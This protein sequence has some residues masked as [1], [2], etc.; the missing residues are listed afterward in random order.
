M[1]KGKVWLGI[2]CTALGLFGLWTALVRWVDVQ[3]IGPEGSKI[4]F[5]TM[6]GW[7][8]AVT[9]VDW[10]LYNITDWLGLVPIAVCFGFA[11]LGL[12]QWIRR[13]KI[14][15]V[16]YDIRCLGVYYLTVI[17]FY[18]LFEFVTLNYRPVLIDGYLEGS[19][20]SS[21]TLLVLCVMP[22]LAEQSLRRIRRKPLAI[23]AIVVSVVFSVYMVVGRL[24]S[25]VHWLSDIIG[26]VMLSAGLFCCYE[27]SV[28][29]YPKK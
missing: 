21:T 1:K 8:H 9:D 25:G 12:V 20:P 7:F 13:K 6:N 14:M 26:G 2:G 19:Y 29:L 22:T 18:L 11:L 24:L 28:L 10:R 4:G 3:T 15:R 17:L 16:D 27:A 5:A 23:G